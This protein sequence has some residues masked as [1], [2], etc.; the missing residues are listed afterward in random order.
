MMHKE[1]YRYEEALVVWRKRQ[2]EII[3]SKGGDELAEWKEQYHKHVAKKKR[4]HLESKKRK[5]VALVTL[6]KEVEEIVV[7][8]VGSFANNNKNNNKTMYYLENIYIGDSGASCH[9]VHSDEGM[10]DVKRRLPSEMGNTL[11][12]SKLERKK[13]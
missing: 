1:K 2:L 9:M 3:C 7:G 11:K 12:H 13:E 4:K 8:N 6:D 10:Y 5:N